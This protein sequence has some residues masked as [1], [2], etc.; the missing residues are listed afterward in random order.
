MKRYIRT[1]TE[2]SDSIL[3][4]ANVRGRKIKVGSG[5]KPFSFYFSGKNSN[6]GIRV[7][8]IFNPDK[9]LASKAGTLKLCDDWAYTPGEDDRNVSSQDIEDMKEFFREYLVLFCAVWEEQ[10]DDPSLQDYFE[11]DIS[12]QELIQ[13]LSFYPEHQADLDQIDN[14]DDLETYCFKNGLVNLYGNRY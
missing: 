6:H 9:M 5:K 7:K 11:G 2:E 1:E 8:P 13:Q 3:C 4:H 14:V 12:F 10:L